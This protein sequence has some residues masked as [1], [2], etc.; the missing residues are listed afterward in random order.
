M[1]VLRSPLYPRLNMMDV[2]LRCTTHFGYFSGLGR[3]L[4]VRAFD[5]WPN[6]HDAPTVDSTNCRTHLPLFWTFSWELTGASQISLPP[7]VS[8]QC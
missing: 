3:S 1:D 7:L 8:G 5:P 4:G 2:K 6:D